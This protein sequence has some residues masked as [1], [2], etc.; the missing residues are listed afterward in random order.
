MT[1][2]IYTPP[3]PKIIPG[4]QW[5]PPK[6]FVPNYTVTIRKS[7]LSGR[8]W[9]LIVFGVIVYGQM[10]VYRWFKEERLLKREQREARINILPLL[11]A[12][13]DRRYLRL[14]AAVLEEEAELMKD[15][16]NWKVGESPYKN[17]KTS[18]FMNEYPP[19]PF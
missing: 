17:Y 15:D 9:F 14:R 7:G 3:E 8:S 4:R 19:R 11:Q 6:V 1:T 2:P 10:A 12:E 16:P 13:E 5:K 18:V